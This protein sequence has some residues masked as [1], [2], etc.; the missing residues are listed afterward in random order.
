MQGPYDDK[1]SWPMEEGFVVKLLNQTNDDGHHS[2]TVNVHA[3]G[4]T[5]TNNMREAWCESQFVRDP[6]M[7]QYLKYDSMMF[8]VAEYKF[9]SW[10]GTKVRIT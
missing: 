1:L 6:P 10:W 5:S 4:V 7:S 8:E 3:D 9:V 2:R